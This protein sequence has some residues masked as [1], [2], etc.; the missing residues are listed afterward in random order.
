MYHA[1]ENGKTFNLN[2]KKMINL[3]ELNELELKEIQGGG[4]ISDWIACKVDSFIDGW[5]SWKEAVINS[6][7]PPADYEAAMERW[8][9]GSMY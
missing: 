9:R 2:R 7:V 6:E 4:P 1:I 8:Q 3:D 5:N